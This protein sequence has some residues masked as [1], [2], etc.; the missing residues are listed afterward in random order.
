MSS[1]T[2]IIYD[3]RCVGHVFEP[4]SG[5]HRDEVT[6]TIILDSFIVSGHPTFRLPSFVVVDYLSSYGDI[7]QVKI[8][9]FFEHYQKVEIVED[10]D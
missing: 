3:E 6:S 10:D 8:K 7:F 9:T 2:T 1:K 4:M 5:A